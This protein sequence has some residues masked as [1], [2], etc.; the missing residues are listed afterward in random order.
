MFRHMYYM[1]IADSSR[2]QIG[3]VKRPYRAKE[4]FLGMG[5]IKN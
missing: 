3:P 1:V 5:V 2:S 4:K